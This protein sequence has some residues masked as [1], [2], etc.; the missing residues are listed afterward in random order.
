MQNS[1]AI[2]QDESISMQKNETSEILHN[3]IYPNINRS[4][5]LKA[6][7][8][9]QGPDYLTVDCPACQQKGK[10]FIYNDT[11]IITCNAKNNCGK[12]TS[13]WDYVQT[14]KNFSNKETLLELARYAHYNLPEPNAESW[15]RFEI[16]QKHTCLIKDVHDFFVEMLLKPQGQAVRDYLHSRGYSDADI[17][18]MELGCNPGHEETCKYLEKKGYKEQLINDVCQYLPYRNNHQL[19][20]PYRDIKGNITSIWGRLNNGLKEDEQH[21]KYM[22]YTK[23][24]SKAFP[25]NLYKARRHAEIIVVEGFIDALIAS[26]KGMENIIGI[27]G[28]DL[29]KAQLDAII[30]CNTRRIYL[31]LDADK[32]GQVGIDNAIKKLSRAP[33]EVFVVTLPKG[34]KDPD[35]LISKAEEGIQ[36]FKA[37]VDCADSCGTWL[38]KAIVQKHGITTD[39]GRRNAI[40]EVFQW[41]NILK[42]PIEKQTLHDIASKSLNIPH[43]KWQ[44]VIDEAKRQEQQEQYKKEMTEYG[45]AMYHLVG[46]GKYEEA[47]R[48]HRPLDPKIKTNVEIEFIIDMKKNFLIENTPEPPRLINVQGIDGYSPFIVRGI[49]GSVVGSGGIGKTHYLTQAAIAIATGHKFL[50]KYPIEKQGHVIAIYGENTKDDI[51]RLIRKTFKGLCEVNGS[52]M[53]VDPESI[54]EASNNIGIMSVHGIDA[55]FIDK[56]GN[57]TYFYNRLLDDLKYKACRFDDGIALIII[58]PASRFLGSD[59]ETNNAMA[60]K[61]IALLEAMIQQIKGAPTILFG[62]HMN[63]ASLSTGKSDQSSS[64]GSSALTDGPRLQINLESVKDSKVLINQKMA[65][66]N[67]TMIIEE[68]QLRKDLN[69]CLS[70][71]SGTSTEE[72]LNEEPA[73]DDQVIARG[74]ADDSQEGEIIMTAEQVMGKIRGKFKRRRK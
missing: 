54:K 14:P 18:T 36:M 45:K 35:E 25:I 2:E 12:T 69:G 50:N 55:A 22:P 59:A 70:A 3:H 68:Q 56:D 62:H 8:P 43:E 47:E 20:I 48:L 23:D 67:H 41:F 37:A 24:A 28:R 44:S 9:K 39:V 42:D 15:L 29:T 19:T 32:S 7:N 72:E 52:T 46:E 74:L 58:D 71:C 57:P 26:A 13:L 63:K 17:F 53:Q 40:N 6:L 51:H 60:T 66:S 5:L 33:I 27:C 10:A 65:K 38:A 31:A 1:L 11:T 16:V 73:S 64:R 34:Y 21:Q 49:V 61:F 4:E 30:E